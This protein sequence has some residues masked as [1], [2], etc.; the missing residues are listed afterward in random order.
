MIANTK[1]APECVNLKDRFG[2]RFKVDYE[3]SYFAER[4]IRSVVDPWLM[5]VLCANGEIGPYG[6][7]HLLAC[8]RSRG[9]V[10]KAL[11]ALDCIEVTQDGDDGINAKFHVDDFDRVAEIMRPRRRR[12]LTE[13]QKAASVERLSRFRFSAARQDADGDHSRPAGGRDD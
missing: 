9:P 3:E 4:T 12:R 1:P 10:A 6:G 7:E 2:D 8:T 5:I 11:K 13:E